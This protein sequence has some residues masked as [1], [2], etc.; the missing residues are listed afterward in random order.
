MAWKIWPTSWN[1]ASS[2]YRDNSGPQIARYVSLWN[3]RRRLYR[4]QPEFG[5]NLTLFQLWKSSN[6]PQLLDRFI[7]KH[8][9]SALK[10]GFIY[11]YSL[12]DFSFPFSNWVDRV[13]KRA[14]EHARVEQ[15]WGDVVWWWLKKEV[16][17]VGCK[18]IFFC[19]TLSTC[20]STFQ[21]T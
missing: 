2:F 4:Y 10:S 13:S 14:N 11:L 20:S 6:R 19:H 21:I 15:T 1:T 9:I 17:G 16:E 18:W 12:A 7:K 3:V 8:F 5:P